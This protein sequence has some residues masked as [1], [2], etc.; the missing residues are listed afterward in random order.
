[1]SFSENKK[2]L[3]VYLKTK[4]EDVDF[5]E[6]YNVLNKVDELVYILTRRN[7]SKFKKEEKRKEEYIPKDSWK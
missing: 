4:F 7:D 3:I 6:D 5:N 1:M 2:E